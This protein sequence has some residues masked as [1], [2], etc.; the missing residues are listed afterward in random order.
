MPMLGNV[1]SVSGLTYLEVC[2]VFIE[3][4]HSMRMKLFLCCIILVPKFFL[5]SCTSFLSIEMRYLG[6]CAEI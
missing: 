3:D 4:V 2:D 6:V 5:E 1:S